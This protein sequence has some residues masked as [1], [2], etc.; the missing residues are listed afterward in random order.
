VGPALEYSDRLTWVS[1]TKVAP[2]RRGRIREN[3]DGQWHSL[4][5]GPWR[6]SSWSVTLDPH[7]FGCGT[8]ASITLDT[9]EGAGRGLTHRAI[10]EAIDARR[11]TIGPATATGWPPA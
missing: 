11:G 9:Q 4:P 7:G 8:C 1:G 2:L 6:T 5:G 10:R 3:T